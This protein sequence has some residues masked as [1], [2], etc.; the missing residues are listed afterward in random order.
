LH[1]IFKRYEV[2]RKVEGGGVHG[3]I[4]R[5]GYHVDGTICVRGRGIKVVDNIKNKAMKRWMDRR[6]AGQLEG[7]KD[8]GMDVYTNN[9]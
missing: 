8:R 5:Y 4:V 2:G 6:T 7:D 1:G 9:L 3:L